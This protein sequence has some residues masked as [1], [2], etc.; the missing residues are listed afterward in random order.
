M[1]TKNSV[2]A[3][4]KNEHISINVHGVGFL[5]S[6]PESQDLLYELFQAHNTAIQTCRDRMEREG[7][8]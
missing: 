8:T 7:K 1:T 3:T 4:V 6:I 5:I 2:N